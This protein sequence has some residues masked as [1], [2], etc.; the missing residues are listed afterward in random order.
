[1]YDDGT[2]RGILR[3]KED[4][5]A[6]LLADI[7]DKVSRTIIT[8]MTADQIYFY[9]L[10][11][12]KAWESAGLIDEAETTRWRSEIGDEV[13]GN[14]YPPL[15]DDSKEVKPI[16]KREWVKFR[17]RVLKTHPPKAGKNYTVVSPSKTA[18]DVREA[19]W[20]GKV[21][22]GPGHQMQV[23]YWLKEE[24]ERIDER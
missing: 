7:H 24:K 10:G 5:K 15:Y 11:M 12:M 8:G 21:W 16:V 4:C 23:T 1:M 14:V 20:T 3:T 22:M 18:W 17:P 6:Y 2:G 13:E 19:K 9:A